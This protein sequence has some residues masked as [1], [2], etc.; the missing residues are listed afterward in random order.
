LTSF[1]DNLDLFMD[2]V[3]NQYYHLLLMANNGTTKNMKS[4]L[5]VK[6]QLGR[7]QVIQHCLK[8]FLTSN[9]FKG[10][11]TKEEINEYFWENAEL[12]ISDLSE[13]V[14]MGET[15]AESESESESESEFEINSDDL[16]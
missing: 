7:N 12:L 14:N 11:P 9:V 16:M 3:N 5:E 15:D 4:L 13:W 2:R 8:I 1:E 10:K 6:A